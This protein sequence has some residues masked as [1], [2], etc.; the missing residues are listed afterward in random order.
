M[1]FIVILPATVLVFRCEHCR[2]CQD[3]NKN[4]ILI[5]QYTPCERNA[6]DFPPTPPTHSGFPPRRFVGTDGLSKFTG[7]RL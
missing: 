7:Y 2:I 5:M 6:C 3:S 1:Q 4:P